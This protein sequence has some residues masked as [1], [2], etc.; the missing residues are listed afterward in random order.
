MQIARKWVVQGR[1]IDKMEEW[2]NIKKK[3]KSAKPLPRLRLP[4]WG[5]GLHEKP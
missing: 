2:A 4:K 5:A 3:K 1:A